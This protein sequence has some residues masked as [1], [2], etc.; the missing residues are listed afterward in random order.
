MRL[1]SSSHI[2][3][4]IVKGRHNNYLS[5]PPYSH[6][7]IHTMMFMQ[8]HPCKHR[9]MQLC[10]SNYIATHNHTSTSTLTSTLPCTS[11]K[12]ISIHFTTIHFSHFLSNHA[13]SLHFPPRRHMQIQFAPLGCTL[14]LTIMFTFTFTSTSLPLRRTGST[15]TSTSPSPSP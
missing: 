1:H 2:C 7:I 3:I 6:T 10:S 5:I 12:F 8:L 4:R 15:V 11:L 13:T 9:V 14:P